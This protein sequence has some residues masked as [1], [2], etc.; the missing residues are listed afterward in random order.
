MSESLES[1][2]IHFPHL[3]IES[4]TGSSNIHSKLRSV[5]LNFQLTDPAGTLES[6]LTNHP[7]SEVF[8]CAWQSEHQSLR[9]LVSKFDRQIQIGFT[10]K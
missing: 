7:I 3:K 9:T 4:L 8:I 2:A 6:L 5:A 10:C 1:F